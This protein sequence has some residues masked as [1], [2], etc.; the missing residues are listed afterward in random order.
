MCLFCAYLSKID[1]CLAMETRHRTVEKTWQCRQ[2]RM[3]EQIRNQQVASSILAGGSMYLIEATWVYAIYFRPGGLLEIALIDDVVV[4]EYASRFVTRNEHRHL[5]R[6]S[7]PH[8]V[9]YGRPAQIMKHQP[10]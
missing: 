10:G 9:P 5:L 1:L 2:E 6:S 8:H 4:F 3:L 7:C